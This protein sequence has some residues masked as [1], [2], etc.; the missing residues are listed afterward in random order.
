MWK[1]FERIHNLQMNLNDQEMEKAV[2]Q[3]TAKLL[4]EGQS[5]FDTE[6]LQLA[7]M[8][9][10]KMEEIKTLQTEVRHEKGRAQS[11]H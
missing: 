3:E 4:N 5:R 2:A 1:C 8:I 9:Q 11:A 10:N 7:E 6:K